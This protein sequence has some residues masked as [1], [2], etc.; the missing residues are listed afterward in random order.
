MSSKQ[1]KDSL[2]LSD[3]ERK[4]L[5]AS[6]F[7]EVYPPEE[8]I[9]A[10]V[11]ENFPALGK[12]AAMRFVE[13]VQRNPGGVISLP[14]G[15]TPEHFIKWVQRLLRH[16]GQPDIQAELEAAEVDPA[17]TPDMKS[18]H[19]VQIDEFY[20]ISPHQQNSFY[21]YVKHFYV[22]G[23]GLDPQKAM[24]INCSKIALGPSEK[25]DE[26][27]PDLHVDLRLRYSQPK[28]YLESRQKTILQ[29]I[30]QWC[31]EYEDKIRTLGGIGFF[32]G[33]I[34]PDGHI[35]F[36]ISGSD[37][38][39]TTRLCPIN[40]ETQAA[41]A[42][43]LGGIEIAKKSLVIT[44]GLRTITWNPDC[45]AIIIAAG[46]AKASIVAAAI[47]SEHDINV[48]A[49]ALHNLANA[50]FYLTKGA[51][52][53]LKR[54]RL[55]VLEKAEKF[56][57][58]QIEKILIDLSVANNKKLTDLESSDCKGDLFGAMLLRMYPGKLA[59]LARMTRDNIIKKIEQGIQVST[60]K[61]FLHT[62]P[63]HDDVMLGYFARLVRHS[64]QPSNTHYF[65]TLTS[66]F[67][68]VTNHFMREQLANLRLFINTAG[69]KQ[70]FREGYF[71]PGNMAC[72]N[73]DIWQYLDGVAGKNR[74][75]KA[76]GCAR[77][78]LRNLVEVFE[79]NWLENLEGR[80]AEIEKYFDTQYPG[81]QDLDFIQKLKGMCREWEAECLWGYFGWNCNNITHLRLS[82]YKG[83]IFTKEPTT[84]QDVPPIVQ[85][86]QKADPDVVTV[87]FDPEGSGPD[88]HYKV[89]QAIAEALKIYQKQTGRNDLEIW[90]YRNVW[91]QFDL[92]EA[93]V[94]V[95]VS[96]N[97]FAIMHDAF[98]NSFISQR[99]ASFPSYE[100]DGPFSELAQK[101]QVRQYQKI[102]TCLG[103][104][105]FNEH[106]SPLIRAT[107]GMILLRKMDPQ[108]FHQSCRKLQKSIET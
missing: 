83:D 65:T 1:A 27:W 85:A 56:D 53:G 60:D 38:Y 24:M 48:P 32:L 93:N 23:F 44:I 81:K 74:H 76:E 99:D 46:A 14:T 47:Q 5:S 108:E 105:W 97:M 52:T 29:Q 4:A 107:R 58:E 87:A 49:T 77:R 62:E 2:R 40:Y 78:F 82:F 59:E 51:A 106:P 89:L 26:I 3:V 15:K 45:A 104:G 36:N 13:W 68:S 75:L 42:T 35:G 88:T 80:I 11:V 8:K 67:T 43:D 103:R 18:L 50:R 10:I 20:P 34:G 64:R 12:L 19:F 79:D 84:E 61:R 39:S 33:G 25:L 94:F 31:M 17:K 7:R 91:Y 101:I 63:H 71:E 102:K 73:R 54:R 55:D 28:N 6:S 41:A 30:D 69:F 100:Y 90:G 37:H 92:T 16:W 70:M 96:L 21:N 86:L 72:R 98:M 22:E 95:P 66:G 57:D 9:P